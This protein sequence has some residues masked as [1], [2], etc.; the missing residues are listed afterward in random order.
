MLAFVDG[1]VNL[2]VLLLIFF[3]PMLVDAKRKGISLAQYI[4]NLQNED[5]D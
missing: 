1:F 5:G 2:A 3:V 4:G